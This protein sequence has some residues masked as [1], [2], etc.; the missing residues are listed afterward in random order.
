MGRVKD[1]ARFASDGVALYDA[2]VTFF[3][4]DRLLDALHERGLD[5]DTIVVATADHG[6]EF[7]EHGGWAHGRALRRAA[8]D[9]A[10]PAAPG[11]GRGSRHARRARGHPVDNLPTSWRSSGWLPRRGCAVPT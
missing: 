7:F 3:D 1:L 11:D 10:P 5:R 9:P 6:E 8:Q 2:K 4:L